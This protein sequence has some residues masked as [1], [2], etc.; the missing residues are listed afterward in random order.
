MQFHEKKL[1]L[2]DLTSFFAWTFFNF[3]AHCETLRRSTQTRVAFIYI[4]QVH[5][6][7]RSQRFDV[8]ITQPP[9]K[10]FK[11]AEEEDEPK[12][13]FLWLVNMWTSP[14]QHQ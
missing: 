11:G 12:E 2:F 8:K 3:L 1:D 5:N 13:N 7:Y 10:F 9:I 14:N 6:L 4:C